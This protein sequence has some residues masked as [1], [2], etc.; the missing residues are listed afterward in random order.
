MFNSIVLG[1]HTP[2]G[3][4]VQQAA[5]STP[6]PRDHPRLADIVEALVDR[7]VQQVHGKAAC[8]TLAQYHQ[9]AIAQ[10]MME[11]LQKAAA[12]NW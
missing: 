1:E 8:L 5:G 3:T 9:E 12:A 2:V 7:R 10:G 6:T 4:W 11:R